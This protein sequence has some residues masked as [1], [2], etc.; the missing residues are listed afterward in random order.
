MILG[1]RLLLFVIVLDCFLYFG[2]AAV[3]APLGGFGGQIGQLVD[4]NGSVNPDTN[5]LV[6]YTSGGTM[7][8]SS[9]FGYQSFGIDAIIGFVGMIYGIM[10]VPMNFLYWL[11]A[12]LFA[13]V[14][15]GGTYIVMV[16]ASVAQ[17]LTGRFA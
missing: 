10:T 13:Q 11:G 1:A 15:V 6:N 5:E 7:V 9:A 3:G 12:P 17:L 8:Q 14:L 2:L 16:L 4:I